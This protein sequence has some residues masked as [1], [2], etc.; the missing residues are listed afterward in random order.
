MSSC[1]NPSH[2]PSSK[3]ICLVDLVNASTSLS[4]N[5]CTECFWIGIKNRV[6]PWTLNIE[7]RTMHNLYDLAKQ[8]GPP[9]SLPESLKDPCKLARFLDY[10]D[11]E[12]IG[13]FDFTSF[14]NDFAKQ[15][16][17]L[18]QVD[19]RTRIKLTDVQDAG[20]RKNL[21]LRLW[22]GA[23]DAAKAIRDKSADYNPDGSRAPDK[24]T[25]PW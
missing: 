11:K 25:P 24:I 3:S 4:L 13:K 17:F 9:P 5:W 21:T 16:R 7:D 14:E 20:I 2:N 18:A 22:A 12:I 19:E 23:W 8:L 1:Q 15:H 10:V 6:L